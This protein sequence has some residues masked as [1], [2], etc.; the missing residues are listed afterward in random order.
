MHNI[1]PVCFSYRNITF[2][3]NFDTTQTSQYTST[4]CVYI[5]KYKLILHGDTLC[6]LQQGKSTCFAH[7]NK[8]ST[9]NITCITYITNDPPISILHQYNKQSS[10][11]NNY[12]KGITHVRLL[13]VTVFNWSN[14]RLLDC[15]A[16][17]LYSVYLFVGR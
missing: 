14:L 16:L 10:G 15:Q 13:F 11:K 3:N 5:T 1:R 6:M 12:Y 4:M 2:N 9:Y 8:Y 17:T 7:A